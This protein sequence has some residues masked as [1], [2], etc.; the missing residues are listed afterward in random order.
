M[1]Q[2]VWVLYYCF[3]LVVGVY[4][5]DSQESGTAETCAE[6]TGNI[7]EVLVE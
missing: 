5:V 4:A 2:V 6:Q 7:Y 1:S 3:G